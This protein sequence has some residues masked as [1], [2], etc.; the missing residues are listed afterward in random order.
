MDLRDRLGAIGPKRILA[1]D[2]GGI[3]SL[4]SLGFLEQIEALL[5]ERHNNPDLRLYQYF[6]LIG[7]TSTGAVLAAGLA[8]GMDVAELKRY[9]IRLSDKTFIRSSFKLWELFFKKG[10]IERELNKFFADITLGSTEIQTGLCVATKRADTNSI[11]LF[12][13]HPKDVYY[14]RFGSIL[15][16]DILYASL[17]GKS[18]LTPR[19]ISLKPDE[20]AAFTDA[21]VSVVNNPAFQLFQVAVLQGYP[22]RWP[23][24][25]HRLMLVSVGTGVMQRR[26]R[27]EKIT[28][29]L[30]QDNWKSMVPFLMAEEAGRQTQLI[31]QYLSRSATPW[32]VDRD[33]GNLS[34]D[35]LTPEPALSYL[36]YD[37]RLNPEEMKRLGFEKSDELLAELREMKI[38]K[39][40]DM[41]LKIGSASA[42]SAI[43]DSH[44]PKVF[45]LPVPQP[46]QIEQIIPREENN[47]PQ[48][49][50]PTPPKGEEKA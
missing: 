26:F 11:R 37:V 7:G 9:Y 16:R 36:R 14:S 6:D 49:T 27:V 30:E 31:L 33:A 47:I 48:D 34:L 1:I 20:I 18:F 8:V 42:K 15:L 13:N 50:P 46:E 35:L 12:L 43:S 45:D 17:G 22:F 3:R 24:G 32:E 28:H 44:F 41:L 39:Q 2:G 29:K 25:E 40:T 10:P 21:G 5:R 23:I 19:K 38:P 4:I